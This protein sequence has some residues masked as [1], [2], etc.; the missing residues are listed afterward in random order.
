MLFGIKAINKMYA[1]S[2]SVT[3]A[4]R[5]LCLA[6]KFETDLSDISMPHAPLEAEVTKNGTPERALLDPASSHHL[7]SSGHAP[8]SHPG[9]QCQLASQ[10]PTSHVCLS[11]VNGK[12]EG[13]Q[14]RKFLLL[15]SVTRRRSVVDATILNFGKIRSAKLR[16]NCIHPY[17]PGLDAIQRRSNKRGH[18]LFSHALSNVDPNG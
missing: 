6:S 5:F 16:A 17:L 14:H 3:S 13:E 2:V 18:S 11:W 15:L 9:T 12:E 8:A 1:F 10:K 7:S 4:T